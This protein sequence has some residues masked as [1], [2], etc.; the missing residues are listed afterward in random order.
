MWC[1][2]LDALGGDS[3]PPTEQAVP[4]NDSAVFLRAKND[5]GL[6][7][8]IKTDAGITMRVNAPSPGSCALSVSA[9][10]LPWLLHP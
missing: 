2:G 3:T 5:G 4:T 10:F 7:A 8:C 6:V 1:F 9:L